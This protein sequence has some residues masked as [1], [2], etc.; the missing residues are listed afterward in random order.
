M[1][2]TVYDDLKSKKTELV[3]KAL[4]G[5]AFLAPISSDP[6]D[7]LTDPTDMLLAALPEGYDDLGYVSTDGF[8]FGREVEQ[9]DIRAHGATDAVR[10]DITADSSTLTVQCIETKLNTIGLYTGAD[11]SALEAD[12]T[13]GELVIDKPSRPRGQ[14]YRLLKVS[15][16]LGDDGEIYIARFFPRAKVTNFDEQAFTSD[17]E[18]PI[19]WPVTLTAFTDSTL[20]FSERWLFGGPGWTALLTDMGI[21]QATP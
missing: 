7:V 10:S 17:G 4:D 2:G 16:D 14:Y 13:S 3:R 19:T 11:V 6:I 1:A 20:G 8:S 21:T 12:A 9:A 5:S 18:T 15:V